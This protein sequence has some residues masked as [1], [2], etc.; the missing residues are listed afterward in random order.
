MLKDKPIHFVSVYESGTGNENLTNAENIKR[1]YSL[2]NSLKEQGVPFQEVHGAYQGK[3]E[4]SLVFHGD[5][6]LPLINRLAEKFNQDSILSVGLDGD[7]ILRYKDGRTENIGKWMEISPQEAKKAVAYTFDPK[8][9]KYW[10]A[11]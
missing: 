5:H 11:R 2:M 9:G 8:T 3:P 4:R 1:H 10:A 7:A 6:N